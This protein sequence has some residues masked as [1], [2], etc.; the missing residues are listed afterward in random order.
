MSKWKTRWIVFFSAVETFNSLRS[1][2]KSEDNYKINFREQYEGAYKALWMS[3]LRIKKVEEALFVAE[4]GRAQTLSDNLLIQYK[5]NASL[6]SAKIDTKETISRLFAKL[7]SPTLFLA[8]DG[9]IINIWFLRKGKKVEFQTGRLECDR[10]EKDPLLALLQSSLE[11]IRAGDTK[12]CEDRTFDEIDN[13]CSFSIEVRGKG[14]GKPP[15]PPLDNPLKPF[16]DAVIDPILDML[17]PQDDELVIVS[18]GALCFIPWA[19]VIEQLGFARFH[20]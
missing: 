19:A 1:L 17:E 15:L 5:L 16:Y 9:F 18:D 7:S 3:L 13:E 20:H 14:V 8:I 6:S 10:R 11:K 4:E 12:R 2:L